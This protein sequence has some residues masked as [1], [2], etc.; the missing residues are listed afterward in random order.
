MRE[1]KREVNFLIEKGRARSVEMERVC[2]GG[3][4]E[5]ETETRYIDQR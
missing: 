2:R 5:R 3:G 4:E 1:K